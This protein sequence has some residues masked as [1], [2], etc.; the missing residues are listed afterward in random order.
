MNTTTPIPAPDSKPEARLLECPYCGA[1][2]QYSWKLYW[3]APFNILKCPSCRKNL[4]LKMPG[5]CYLLIFA[6]MFAVMLAPLFFVFGR[7]P[8]IAGG[9]L[10]VGVAF[11]V[12]IDK[13]LGAR[14]GELVKV[15]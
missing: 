5:W 12:I 9:A 1:R 8:Q 2:F 3:K 4:K 7:N 10:L 14:F 15:E 6:S 11:G 13:C